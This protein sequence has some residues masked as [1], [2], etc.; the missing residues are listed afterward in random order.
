MFS[1]FLIGLREGLEAALVVG[2]I[3]AYLVKTNRRDRLPAVWMGVGVAA[4]LSLFFGAMLTFGSSSLSHEAQ[5]AF[6]GITSIVAVGLVTWM[7]FWMSRTARTM[8]TELHNKVD[9]VVNAGTIAIAAMAALAVGREGLE[10][11]LFLWSNAQATQQSWQPIIGAVLGI[12]AAISL[13]YLIY[14]RA[15]AINL[16]K[17]FTV[18]GAALI[19][20]AAG[21]LAYGVHDLQEA[22]WLPGIDNLAYNISNWYSASSWYGTLLKGVFNFSPSPTVI[23]VG[24]WLLYLVP[25]AIAFLF[26][27]RPPKRSTAAASQLAGM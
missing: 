18:T 3:L 12:V 19:V 14:R 1:N 6:A 10:T 15:I 11:A 5:E 4:G 17:F 27:V 16:S 25:V 20:V 2:I 23:E 26:I 21:V 13:G 22:G 24:V 9:H 8:K 7:I